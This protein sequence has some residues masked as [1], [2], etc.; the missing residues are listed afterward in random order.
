MYL[1]GP[2]LGLPSRMLDGCSSIHDEI[3]MCRRH[4]NARGSRRTKPAASPTALVGSWRQTCALPT[5]SPLRDARTTC[6]G[7]DPTKRWRG[8]MTLHRLRGRQLAA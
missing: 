7:E 4:W 1:L 2:P 3:R 6:G 8:K 5:E